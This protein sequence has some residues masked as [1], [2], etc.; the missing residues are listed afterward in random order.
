[1]IYENAFLADE[2]SVNGAVVGGTCGHKNQFQC[3]LPER[4][5][6]RVVPACFV[7]AGIMTLVDG[8][9]QNII[10]IHV[11]ASITGA[12]LID[13]TERLASKWEGY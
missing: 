7:Y 13:D 8:T 9:Y 12:A 3:V 10:Y 4:Q 6:A 2:Y 1:M 5:L 11:H